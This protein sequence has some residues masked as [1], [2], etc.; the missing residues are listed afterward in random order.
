MSTKTAPG[1]PRDSLPADPA[2]AVL[3]VYCLIDAITSDG[4]EIRNLGKVWWILLILF[5]P[6]TGAIAW[7]V[8]GRPAPARAGRERRHRR[9]AAAQPLTVR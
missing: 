5:F 2:G 9:A 6:I 1:D 8:G 7:L 3:L 4:S